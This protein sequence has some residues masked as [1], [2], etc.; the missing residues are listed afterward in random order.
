MRALR[1]AVVGVQALLVFTSMTAPAVAQVASDQ[2]G[3]NR[4]GTAGK[5]STGTWQVSAGYE[6]FSF[7]QGSSSDASQMQW[8]GSGPVLMAGHDIVNASR[9][10]RFQFQI[11]STG[12]FSYESPLRA[13]AAPSGDGAS[14]LEG[15]YE[16]RRYLF[17]KHLPSWV[18]LGV[19]ALAFGDRTSLTR[20][21]PPAIVI[22]RTT[23]SIG[24][25]V[26]VAGG[27]HT[28][29]LSVDAIWVNTLLAGTARLQHSAEPATPAWVWDWKAGYRSGLT[30][31][32]ATPLTRHAALVGSC[33]RSVE[34]NHLGSMTA[35]WFTR[36]HF[37]L[38]VIYGR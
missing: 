31:T 19:G 12:S 21:V 37:T 34:N 13:T 1:I 10:H 20:N 36:T 33:Y 15:Q 32:A 17:R 9:L 8:T 24:G 26:A 16:Y 38:G 22:R 28:R 14:H 2:A 3:D 5:P 25:G 23:V 30:L 18:D 4:A 11:S 35:Q 29:R 6:T 27:F 7:R